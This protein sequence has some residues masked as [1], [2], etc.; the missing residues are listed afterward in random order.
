MGRFLL[1]T[2]F[3]RFQD[4]VGNLADG[5]SIWAFHWSSLTILDGEKPHGVQPGQFVVGFIES[6]IDMCAAVLVRSNQYEV[7]SGEN[8]SLVI[9]EHRSRPPSVE[10][11]RIAKWNVIELC[12]V[13][14]LRRTD[15]L[16]NRRCKSRSGA[17][18]PAARAEMIDAGTGASAGP[19]LKAALDGAFAQQFA[20]L[21]AQL[22]NGLTTGLPKPNPKAAADR[23]AA[24]IQSVR[25]ADDIAS[26]LIG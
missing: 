19:N 26:K 15:G 2:G 1:V 3:E 23:F 17:L 4:L 11:G 25:A 6:W 16:E 14:S 7:L 20:V 13:S 21:F 18:P 8:L 24:N 9:H 12:D 22:Y 5:G 10:W